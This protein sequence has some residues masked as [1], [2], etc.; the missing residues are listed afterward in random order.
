MN[1][2][3]NEGCIA[4]E[5]EVA[6]LLAVAEFREVDLGYILI[7]TDDVSGEKWDKRK[8]KTPLE[9]RKSIIDLCME[10]VL[11]L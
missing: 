10:T 1:A 8:G 3:I 5:M 7:G 9:F 6:A 4:V 2:R 11:R